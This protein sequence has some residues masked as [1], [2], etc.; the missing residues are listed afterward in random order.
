MTATNGT[1]AVVHAIG[2]ALTGF[3]DCDIEHHSALGHFKCQ[4]ENLDNFTV[5]RRQFAAGTTR[6]DIPFSS[7][8]PGIQM[9]FSLDAPSFFNDKRNPLA[10]NPSSHS[11]NLF[12]SYEC[13]NLLA[14]NSRQNDIA[15]HLDK[16]FY[17]DLITHHLATSEDR[18]PAMILQQQEFNTINQHV[19]TDTALAGILHNILHC[20]FAGA[21][22]Q[23][24]LRE[25]VNALFTLQLFHFSQVVT[26]TGIKYPTHLSP[27]DREILH[28]VK[29]YIDNQ[30][31][32][33]HSLQLLS[34]HFGINAFKLKHGF[35]VLFDT[36]PIRY[37]QVKRLQYSRTLLMETDLSLKQIANQIG[38][39]HVANF[40]TAFK[41]AYGKQPSAY[42]IN[43]QHQDW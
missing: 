23:A 12:K 10:L 15:F 3:Q 41:R 35:K 9:I 30:F 24:F 13:C 33:P 22:R 4:I 5:L 27:A 39:A 19:R 21:M 40:T 7:H 25:H 20:P 38:Y 32:D 17:T 18:L 8:Q 6:V 37:L 31:L 14:A 36:S 16:S 11:L 42:R 1:D 28:E 2:S 29:R 43:R 34:K 26:G